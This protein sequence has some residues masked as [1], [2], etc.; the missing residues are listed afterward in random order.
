MK[1]NFAGD[2]V[3]ELLTDIYFIAHVGDDFTVN[4]VYV[5]IESSDMDRWEK[6]N[7]AKMTIL[8][9]QYIEDLLFGMDINCFLEEL[10]TDQ[11]P[12]P[13]CMYYID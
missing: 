13:E 5:D 2:T 6:L 3:D 12:A 10:V 7:Q 9:T 4:V 1:V 11:T 8:A